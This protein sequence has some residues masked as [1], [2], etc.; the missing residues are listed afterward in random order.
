MPL[1]EPVENPF[2][3][4]HGLSSPSELS[5]ILDPMTKYAVFD[6]VVQDS[7]INKG[8]CMAHDILD[9]FRKRYDSV[10]GFLEKAVELTP[11]A[12]WGKKVGGF[13]Y[14]QQLVHVYGIID[15]FCKEVDAPPT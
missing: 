10:Y 4:Q 13:Y 14:W 9:I 11:D 6:S 12:L 2:K 15:S 1:H 7:T 5:A 3:S 8:D